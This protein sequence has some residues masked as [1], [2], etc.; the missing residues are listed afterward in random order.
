MYGMSFSSQSTGRCVMTSMGEMSPAIT[1]ILHLQREINNALKCSVFSY[2]GLAAALL[3]RSQRGGRAHPV[4]FFLMAFTTSFTPRLICFRLVAFFASLS[5]FFE[6]FSSARGLAMGMSSAF[7][8]AAAVCN[9]GT[10]SVCCTLGT[11]TA[12]HRL[13]CVSYS[14]D[15]SSSLA[16]SEAQRTIAASNTLQVGLLW[17][18]SN[19]PLRYCHIGH[20][21]KYKH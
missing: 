14:A 3:E 16:T 19:A 18:A 12:A 20:K 15:N 8:G 13:A 6:S 7:F 2:T 17:S 9:S 10:H 5:T 4:N 11:L 21:C 1:H